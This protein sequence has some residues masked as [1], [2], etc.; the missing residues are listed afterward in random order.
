[1]YIASDGYYVDYFVTN[2]KSAEVD[3]D[4]LKNIRNRLPEESF[5]QIHRK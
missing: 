2:K 1:M 5:I 4:T 3:R